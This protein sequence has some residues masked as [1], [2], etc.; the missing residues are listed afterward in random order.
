MTAQSR[1]DFPTAPTATDLKRD[2]DTNPRWKGITRTFKPEDVV[3][4]RASLPVEYTIAKHGAIKLWEMMGKKEEYVTALG[5]LTGAQAVQM[6]KAGMKA[7][8]LSGWQVAADGNLSSNTYPDQSLYPSNSVPAL[9]KRLNN[10]LTRADQIGKNDGKMD[11][12]TDWY[13]PIVADAEAGFGG[14]LHAF[15]LMK[16]MIEAGASGVH[17]E[18]QLAS[19]KKCGHLG[20]KVLVPTSQFI[21]TLIAARMAADAL[22]VPT[23][24]IART[25]ALGATLMTSDIDDADKK[26]CTGDR[27]PEGFYRIRNGMP[28]TIARGLAYAPHADLIWFETSKPSLAEAKEFAEA[29]HAKFPGKLLAYN[30]SP[31]FNWKKNLDDATIKTFN[32]EL[33][34]MGYRFQFITLAGWHSINYH[35]FD[36]AQGFATEG[37]PAYVRLQEAEFAK[38]KSGY[39][40]TRHQQEVGTGYF[41]EVLMAITNGESST[42][43]LAGSTETEQF[44]PH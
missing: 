14:P 3:R 6:A 16:S 20:G 38:E 35:A 13:L 19:E 9:V 40:A 7:I 30:C 8:Y 17:F 37:M 24:I 26:F 29:I 15:E 22:N 21:R 39:T 4:L 1:P 32:Q 28:I 33:G 10:A 34:K 12:G 18:D 42:S 25:D 44:H 2:W 23:C 41:D 5:S 31:S 43:A 11:K 36:L 27:T